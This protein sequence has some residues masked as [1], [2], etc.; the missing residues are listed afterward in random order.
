MTDVAANLLT[1]KTRIARAAERVKRDPAK[2]VVI[3]AAKRKPAAMIEAAIAAG[4]EDIG[5]N[6]V[7]EAAEKQA[8]VT[9]AA[10]WHMIGHLQRNKAKR[11]V[12][13]FD[14]IHSVDNIELGRALGRHAET[15]Q[16]PVHVLIEVNLGG[17]ETKSGVGPAAL[18][19]L[20]A[21]LSEIPGL[22]V[23]GLMTMP[24][25][26]SPESAR[27]FFRRLRNLRDQ[28]GLR[29]LSMGMT[30]DF[31]VAVEEG[32]TMVRVGTAIFG[33]RPPK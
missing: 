15:R 22:D 30:A 11:A 3:G 5:E 2:I 9:G 4:L 7:Q 1:V 27:P 18:P 31:E 8:I 17:E 21:A 10:R 23:D 32:A 14:V 16:Q 12:E 20:I 25:P 24:P 6:Y 26:G 33:K 28:L 29:E 19:D 13:M